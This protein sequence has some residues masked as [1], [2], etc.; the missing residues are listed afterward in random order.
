MKKL[1]L[2]IAISVFVLFTGATS[3]NAADFNLDCGNSGCTKSGIEPIFSKGIDGYWFP[4]RTLTKTIHLKNSSSG[5]KEMSIKPNRTSSVTILEHVMLVSI[6]TDPGGTVV[7]A[8][9]LAA[10]YG[11]PSIS[12]GIFASGTDQNYKIN[13]SMNSAADNSYQG[14]ESAFD[15][16]LGFWENDLTPTPTLPS[17]PGGPGDGLSDGKS[18]GLSSCP[19]CTA[20]GN[21]LGATTEGEVLG[22]STDT[23]AATG[24]NNELAQLFLAMAA[25]TAVFLLGRMFLRANETS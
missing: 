12:M 5:T 18:D 3:A 20:P 1:L 9:D 21:V 8:G 14:L 16:T 23:L 13:A 10:F 22:A 2:A 11:Q 19:S 17:N 25:A 4:G 15:L 6:V 7:W 24:G